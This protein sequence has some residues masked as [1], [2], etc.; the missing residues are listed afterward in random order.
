MK[1]ASKAAL[2][3]TAA[4]MI[5]LN[6][7][8]HAD[9]ILVAA[10]TGNAISVDGD[11]SDWDGIAG[12]TVPLT[13]EGGVDSVELKAAIRGDTI[14]VLAVWED[15][16]EDILHKPY[17]WDEAAGSYKS[18]KR[19][20]DRFAIALRMS[21]DFSANKID[22]HEFEADVWHWKASRTNPAGIAHD[23]MWK[24]SKA[25]FKKAKEWTTPDGGTVY[26][27]R[28]SDEGDRLYKPLKY[29][30]KYEE[31]MPRYEVN[32]NPQGSIADVRAMGVWRDGRWYLELSRLLDTG[33]ADDAVI[34]RSGII[35]IAV[36][37]FDHVG[38]ENHSVSEVITLKSEGPSS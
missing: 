23:K 17:K 38:S 28:I 36:A 11:I 10:D 16:T 8:A 34:P 6:A 37:A 5:G 25:P 3:I 35:D 21:G 32:L 15:S 13:G 7:P 33:H 2:A 19:M 22:G 12:I 29:N 9:Q 24:V 18:T 4:A 20:E 14:Y 31:V 27:A 30:T 1:H 26:V